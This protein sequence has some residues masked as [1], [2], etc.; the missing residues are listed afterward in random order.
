[1]PTYEYECEKCGV[2]FERQQSMTDAPVTECPKCRGNVR[3][4]ITGGAGFIFKGSGHGQGNQR[5]GACQL[6]QLGRT[7]CGRDQRCGKPRC[8]GES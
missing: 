2:R 4:L 3:R 8:G 1:M 6:E 5:A 7:C